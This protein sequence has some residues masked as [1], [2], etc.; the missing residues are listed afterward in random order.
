MSGVEAT[1]S[2]ERASKSV[3]SVRNEAE[4]GVRPF[5]S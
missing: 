1:A 4:I 2:D 3:A 5:E